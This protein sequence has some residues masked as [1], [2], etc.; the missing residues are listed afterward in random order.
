VHGFVV[1]FG[2]VILQNEQTGRSRRPGIPHSGAGEPCLTQGRLP[3]SVRAKADQL[4]PGAHRLFMLGATA[5]RA[6]RTC[7]AGFSMGGQPTTPSNERRDGPGQPKDSDSWHWS[8]A[9]EPM[10]RLL[11]RTTQAAIDVAVLSLAYWA[12]YFLRFEGQIELQTLK[13][14]GFTW[15][16]V[17]ALQFGV[18]YLFAVP[19]FTWR[20]VG[21]R[22]AGRV[23]W[24]TGCASAVLLVARL[25]MP[26]VQPHWGYA[27]YGT[28]PSASS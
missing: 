20:Y 14:L 18:L 22:E 9:K 21:L 23:L 11:T 16:Y 8:L 13:L 25:V 24:A 7:Q 26:L 19:R 28:V 17:V 3:A 27:L 15:P 2:P 5:W 10:S 12:A 1:S 4:A 6:E